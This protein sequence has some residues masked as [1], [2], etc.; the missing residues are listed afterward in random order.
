MVS[1][2]QDE[3]IK[4]LEDSR[5]SWKEIA[6][7][8][9]KQLGEIKTAFYAKVRQIQEANKILAFNEPIIQLSLEHQKEYQFIL[10]YD[11]VKLLRSV[12]QKEASP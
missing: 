10:N 1:N 3:K 5:N 11:E 4:K 8:A 2:E 12:L 6:K 7:D 9:E